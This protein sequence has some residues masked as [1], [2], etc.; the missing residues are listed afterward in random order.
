[1]L[2]RSL[3][4]AE[5]QS[6][7]NLYESFLPHISTNYND[8]DHCV[9]ANEDDDESNCIY[10]DDDDDDNNDGND[11]DNDKNT[12]LNCN[13]ASQSVSYYVKLLILPVFPSF[14]GDMKCL[15]REWLMMILKNV[16]KTSAWKQTW[17]HSPSVELKLMQYRHNPIQR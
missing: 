10:N 16:D 5:Y 17:Y 11:D 6:K 4:S 14:H 7:Y 15:A 9:G 3:K 1:V 12:V 2:F 13:R 8:D